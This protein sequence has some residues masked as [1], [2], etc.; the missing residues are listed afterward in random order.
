MEFSGIIRSTRDVVLG[1]IPVTVKKYPVGFKSWAYIKDLE[2]KQVEILDQ[3]STDANQDS[4][5]KQMRFIGAGDYKALRES[6]IER[7]LNGVAAWGFKTAKGEAVPIV[8]EAAE[9]LVDEYPDVAEV[10]LGEIESFNAGLD[11][12]NRKA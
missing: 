11:S 4:T 8:R 5:T 9:A 2:G 10:L 6:N 1:D 12:K 7:I 3:N